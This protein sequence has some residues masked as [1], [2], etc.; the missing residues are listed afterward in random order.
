MSR[1]PRPTAS[2]VF[3]WGLLAVFGV[4]TV[5]LFLP[6][7]QYALLAGLLGYVLYPISSRLSRYLGRTL[8]AAL[9]VV[10]ATVAVVAPVVFIVGIAVQQ[11]TS[12]LQ[13][14]TESMVIDAGDALLARLGVGAD[15]MDVVDM[16]VASMQNGSR[17]LVGNVFT[18]VG[19]TAQF[20]I[21][22]VVFVFLFYYLLRDGDRLVAWTRTV[23]PLE[24]DEMDDL[25]ERCDRLLWA[26]LVGTVVV[27]AVQAALTGVAFAAL[28]F[29]NS[30]FW[31]LVTFL[32]SLLPVIGASVVWI[33]ASIY[34]LV[35]GRTIDAVVLFVAGTF[36]ISG[37]DNLIR[38]FVV[39][40][41]A[42]LNTGLVVVGLFGGL[43]VFGFLG[44]FI[45]P[46][47]VGMAKHLAEVVARRHGA[48]ARGQ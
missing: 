41:S 32:L 20:L 34:L 21:G 29:S 33:P 19:A 39:Q 23:S 10:L 38:P 30:V 9:T 31:T 14:V 47:V 8:G 37:S 44:L 11:A 42:H 28:N 48:D 36:I 6:Y 35:V 22:L 24:R 7:L 1:L 2:T 5:W 45:G 43:A 13:G 25:L 26:S 17:G 40:H 27:A 46:V 12:I 16:L 18:V 4:V 3:L 15:T